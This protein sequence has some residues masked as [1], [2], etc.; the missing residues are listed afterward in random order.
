MGIKIKDVELLKEITGNEKIPVSNGS[1]QPATITVNQILENIPE[2]TIETVGGVKKFEIMDLQDKSNIDNLYKAYNTLVEQMVNAGIAEDTRFVDL[3]LPSGT[4]WATCNL[5]S[6]SID[7]PGLFFQWGDIE[8][9]YYKDGQILDQYG[10]PSDKI[11]DYAHYKWYDGTT[12]YRSGTHEGLIKYYVLEDEDGEYIYKQTSL[13]PED[14]AAIQYN[15]LFSFPSGKQVKELLQGCN[16]TF[17]TLNNQNLVCFESI[18][19]GNKLYAP[20]VQN[21]GDSYTG[22]SDCC[23]WVQQLDPEYQGSCL[24]YKF[25]EGGPTNSVSQIR[26]DRCDG[27]PIRYVKKQ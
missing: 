20:I 18:Y 4:L 12:N 13:Q 23:F 16:R 2:A 8:G 11:F 3:G 15:P 19:N 9:Y 10:K 22:I 5:G 6:D 21:I 7:D 26:I 27:L 1:D 14:N 24:V 25:S 17:V